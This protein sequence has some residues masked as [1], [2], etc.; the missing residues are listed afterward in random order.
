MPYSEGTQQV[1]DSLRASGPFAE[2]VEGESQPITP[3]ISDSFF[4]DSFESSQAVTQYDVNPLAVYDRQRDGTY[5]PKFENFAGATGNEERLANQQSTFDK[6]WNGFLK[7]NAKTLTYAVDATLGTIN[8]IAQGFKE[9]DFSKVWDNDFTDSLDQLNSRLDNELP[10]YKT[11]EEQSMGV[12]QSMG[13]ANFWAEDVGGGMAFV[14]GALL[15]EIALGVLTEGTSIPGSIGKFSFKLGAKAAFKAAG[16][17]L[18]KETAEK[19]LKKAAKNLARESGADF[20]RNFSRSIA[21]KSVGEVFDSA[22]FIARTS[23]FE[24]GMEARHNL[25]DA[26]DS[27]YENFEEL[28]GRRPTY[29]E[30]LEFMDKAV[31]ASNY[32]YSANMAILSVSNAVM[33]GHKFNVGTNFTKRLNNFGNRFIGLG[34]KKG[35]G[36]A[37]ERAGQSV[38]QKALGNAY[39]ILGKPAVEGLWEEGMQGVFGKTM[40]SYMKAQYDPDSESAMGMM[41]HISTAFAEQ[42]G[43]KEGWKE[44]AVGMIIGSLGGTVQGGPIAGTF[45]DSRLARS[46]KL[47][48]TINDMNLGRG[49]LMKRLNSANA[50]A[51]ALAAY[52]SGVENFRT[53]SPE[54]TM[55][56]TEYIKSQ[57]AIKSHKEIRKDYNAMVDNMTFSSDQ[58]D[59]LGGEE[60]L[61]QHKE[62]MKQEFKETLD[63]YKFAVRAVKSIGLDQ[64]LKDTPGNIANMSDALINMVTVGRSSLKAAK[65]IAETIDKVTGES[66]SF[67]HMKFF[68]ELSQDQKENVAE[69]RKKKRKK[70]D[71]EKQAEKYQKQ[72]AGIQMTGRQL[73]KEKQEARRNKASENVVTISQEIDALSEEIEKLESAKDSYLSVENFDIERLN[74]T[75]TGSDLIT[76]MEHLDKLSNYVDALEKSGRG[77]DA[78]TLSNLMN[79]FKEQADA[80]REMNNTLSKMVDTNFFSSK[81]GKWLHRFVRGEK[82]KMSDELKQAIKE[83]DAIID[84]AMH[85]L[86]IRGEGAV[87]AELKSLIEDNQSLSEREKYRL[88]A[89]LRLQLNHDKTIKE[90]ENIQEVAEDSVP[91]VSSNSSTPLV[92]DTVAVATDTKLADEDL[93]NLDVLNGVIDKVIAEVDL[94]RKKKDVNATKILDTEDYKRL[95][96]LLEKKEK[97][98]LSPE[99]IAELED[100]EQ[101]I[102]LWINL[103]GTVVEGLRLSDLVKQKIVLERTKIEPIQNVQEVTSQETLDIAD[104]HGRSGAANYPYGQTYDAVVAKT[105]SDGFVELSGITEE[106]FNE[107]TAG[108]GVVY[109]VNER[110]NIVIED[111]D[112]VMVKNINENTD[113]SILATNKNLTTQFN[114]VLETKEDME[115]NPKTSPLE[116]NFEESFGE[117]MEPDA[118]YDL[119]EGQEL[120]LEVSMS[121]SL[122]AEILAGFKKTGALSKK[123]KKR[124]A[125]ELVIR[126]KNREGNFLGV[127]KAKRNNAPNTNDTAVFEAIRNMIANDPTFLDEVVSGNNIEVPVKG[128]KVEKV[129][130]GHP[131][132]NFSKQPD[133]T[134]A[135]DSKTFTE[136]DIEKVIDT[137]YVKNGKVVTKSGDANMSEAFLALSKK[138]ENSITPFVVLKKGNKN[139]AYPVK[140]QPIEQTDFDEFERIFK[141]RAPLTDKAVALNRFMAGKGI[142]INEPGK[143]FFGFGKSNM[144]QEFFDAR[145]AE[146]KGINYFSDMEAWVDPNSNTTEVLSSGVSIDI[147]VNNPFHSPKLKMDLSDTDVEIVP[148][149]LDEQQQEDL[150]EE[151]A[152]AGVNSFLEFRQKP[153]K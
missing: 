125:E 153:C 61:A 36:Q 37:V 144:T 63:D 72:L 30:T 81:E 73:S 111:T 53:N 49:N 110:G 92:G 148:V 108:V 129:I 33:F 7:F 145:L 28:N 76:A 54:N 151:T 112:G 74:E 68:A 65:G 84:T 100:I 51:Q 118:L 101:D 10:N 141:S 34:V 16:K 32:V 95:N 104:G 12:L 62:N 43:T 152:K 83:N 120:A 41:E 121:D 87:E 59:N 4:Q 69:L 1:I 77:N 60:A 35:A 119:S 42:Y 38:A 24:A 98:G 18:A 90:L 86:E 96:E 8:G 14:T 39:F 105:N 40:Q 113:L 131:N 124:A 11:Q 88:D 135:I 50:Q 15:P 150:D 138:K 70:R 99:E 80:Y 75:P 21:N 122:N 136:Q 130:P 146:M 94:Y 147:D 29:D 79:D 31:T 133:G 44:M 102:D 149:T 97:T 58:I 26:V 3:Q 127:F 55:I 46:K 9:Q 91:L 89:M 45:S 52:D 139:I 48:S 114:I 71:L 6:H 117:T 19:G 2:R 85:K 116:S 56:S 25:H 103:S 93:T 20:M 57:E 78:I 142:N 109:S 134:M 67:S 132:Y 23:N 47:D 66:G 82:Y 128:V 27:Y 115:G 126:I 137:G 140:V 64:N 123:D 107:L 5:I 17:K 106:A 13:T 143:A 22:A